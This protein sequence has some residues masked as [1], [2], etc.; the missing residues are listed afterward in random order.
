RV[1]REYE[2][3]IA[4]LGQFLDVTPEIVAHDLHPDYL[5]TRYAQR[6]PGAVTVGVQHHH[7]HVASLMAER[8]LAGPVLGLAFDGTGYGTDGAA[9]G[10]ELLI[11]DYAE[12]TRLATFRPVSLAGGDMAIR[13][14]WRTALALVDDA[15]EGEA[16][17][18]GLPL[19]RRIPP[20][21]ADIVLRMIHRGFNAP[22]AHGVGR[23]FDA[24]G[25]LLL[26]RPYASYEGQI[27]LELDAAADP[28][29]RGRYDYAIDQAPS[30]WQ[31]DL[32]AAVR[33]AVFELLGGE[34]VPRISARIH[35]T[36]AAVSVDL[37]R[38][39]A[40]A[41]GRLPVALTGGC[42][43]NARL[44]ETIER[45]L[46]PAFTVHLHER[47]PPGDGGIA[48]GQAVVAAAKARSL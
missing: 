46:A 43:Q 36:I 29:E 3:S 33:A 26:D 39:A 13:Q 21:D 44:A 47:V 20:A 2:A 16:P 24:F 17:L 41:A 25:A 12:F 37:V 34:A 14:P 30:P 8:G 35:N 15:F 27:A 18:D 40:R 9:W 6:R 7:A 32:R 23:Y 1:F 4:R 38:A 19:F 45:G 11:A 42:F 5:S 28:A 31:V 48:L 10:G 22:K